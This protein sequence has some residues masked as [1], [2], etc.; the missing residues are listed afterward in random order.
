MVCESG[1]CLGT[2]AQIIH[3]EMCF[4][5]FIFPLTRHTPNSGEDTATL[6]G[7]PCGL[8]Y[9]GCALSTG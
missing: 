3:Q 7:G 1:L 4:D 6:S 8:L 2:Y 9:L 5:S